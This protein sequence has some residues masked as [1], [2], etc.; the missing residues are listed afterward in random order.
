MA[1][2]RPKV[3]GFGFDPS[4]SEHYFQ[5]SISSAKTGD[6]H[7]SEHMSWQKG[8]WE[9]KIR[10]VKSD[11]D[12]RLRVILT[13]EK[14]DAIADVVR[15]EFNRRLRLS[16]QKRGIWKVQ[17]L[18][19]VSRLFGKE[20]VLLAWAIEDADPGLIPVA[21]TNWLGLAPEERWWL[22]TMTNAATG[23]A[24][25][26]K[27]RGWR[28][29]VRF[30]LTENPVSVSQAEQ[31]VGLITKMDKADVKSEK[32]SKKKEQGKLWQF[33]RDEVTA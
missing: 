15:E 32:G 25:E 6:V 11:T 7:I 8:M 9:G 16:D 17:G 23:H 3:E 31:R 18:T 26:G 27:G 19:P 14:W 12:E 1:E 30:A 22:F 10:A 20:L 24:I 13:H 2:V 5:V 21:I 28:K 29:A 4:E 33:S